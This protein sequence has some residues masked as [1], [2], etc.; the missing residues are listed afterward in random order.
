MLVKFKAFRFGK[1][2]DEYHIV[3]G[4]IPPCHISSAYGDP[5]DYEVLQD[6]AS[7]FAAMDSVL[8]E[9]L[10]LVLSNAS[11]GVITLDPD[12][13]P[14]IERDRVAILSIQQ[15][16]DD[17]RAGRYRFCKQY[18]RENFMLMIW[19]RASNAISQL[20]DLDSNKKTNRAVLAGIDTLFRNLEGA[21]APLAERLSTATT[22]G[23][24]EDK[25]REMV[26]LRMMKLDDIFDLYHRKKSSTRTSK[27]W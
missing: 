16:I 11:R 17:I 21:A 19:S 6:V 12:S 3:V 15:Q 4:E 13:Q 22:Q 7:A 27:T 1:R 24:L 26:R 18:L 25:D 20:L 9:V 2:S 5:L 23:V 14:S 8:V 10:A